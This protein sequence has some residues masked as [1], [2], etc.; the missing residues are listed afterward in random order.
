MHVLKYLP[1]QTQVSLVS[2]RAL[3]IVEENVSDKSLSTYRGD[4]GVIGHHQAADSV[5]GG[6]VRRLP[7]QGH[8]DASRTPGD[9][10]GQ[11]TLPDPL[12]TF[13]HLQSAETGLH[14]VQTSKTLPLVAIWNGNT[15]T[16][17][18]LC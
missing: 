10:I 6:Q 17:K 7:G 8:L 15:V 18:K 9:E 2:T 1:K 3:D 12:E 4:A 11:F 14:A 13:M 16:P 5:G